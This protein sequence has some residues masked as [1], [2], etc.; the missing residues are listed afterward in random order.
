MSIQWLRAPRLL[1]VLLAF[2]AFTQSLTPTLTTRDWYF[3]GV[4]SGVAVAI[5]YGIGA[6]FTWLGELALRAVDRRPPPLT[7]K[8]DVRIRL[9]LAV[10]L[11]VALTILTRRAVDAHRWTWERLGHE[12]VDAWLAYGGTILLT[13]LVLGLLVAA[14]RLYVWIR[15]RAIGLGRRWLPRWIAVVVGTVVATWLVA[16][17]LSDWVYQRSLDGLNE[18]FT[19]SDLEVEGSREPPTSQLRSTGPA[20]RVAWEEVGDEGRRFLTRGAT[21][22]RLGEWTVDDAEALEPVRVF[23]GRATSSDPVEQSALALAEMER[24]DAFEREVVLV[25]IPTGTGWINEQIVQPVEYLHGGD[26]ATVAVQYSHLPSP[27]AFL[28]EAEAARASARALIGA[29]RERL[30][31]IPESERPK[32]LVAGESLGS[33]GGSAA[34]DSLDELV[35]TTDASLWVGPP[36]TMHLRREAE[37]TR[38]A[39]SLQIKPVVGDGTEILFANRA[40]DVVGH[41]RSVFLQQADDAIVWWDW[42]TAVEEPDWL[43][44]PLDPAVNPAMRW[45]PGTTFLNLAVDMALSTT[46]EEEQGH[47]YGTQPTLAWAAMLAPDGWDAEKIAHLRTH[48]SDVGR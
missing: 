7:E 5:A 36:P 28:T 24:F 3:Q 41:P 15:D 27:L 21:T 25:V 39:G 35:A 31:E 14:V 11:V 46:F 23:V 9:L 26:V 19:L 12:P 40:A 48:L 22:D 33:F 16:T 43:D 38:S 34:F 30:Q 8:Q 42:P 1:G 2:V 17:A 44:E 37:R 45:Y 32:L 29:V 6:L 18:A 47:M 10:V 20:S 4:V 13:L